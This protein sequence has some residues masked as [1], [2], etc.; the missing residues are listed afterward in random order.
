MNMLERLTIYV[1]E[2]DHWRGKPVYI[3][4]VEEARRRE[5]AGAT[6]T[7]GVMGYGKRNH[8]RIHT[9]RIIELSS[10]LPMVVTIIDTPEA[11][12]SFLPLVKEMVVGGIA[13]QETVNVVHHVP[14]T[15]SPTGNA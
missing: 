7:R 15:H 2:S 10:D 14:T 3:A 5:L 9:A 1:G 13:I 8:H 6:V 4:L 11:I 12:A